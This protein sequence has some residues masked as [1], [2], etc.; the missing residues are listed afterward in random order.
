MHTHH[1]AFLS[2]ESFLYDLIYTV[3]GF[4]MV[5]HHTCSGMKLKP[6]ITLCVLVYKYDVMS[7]VQILC[8]N[9]F[10]KL[11]FI[12]WKAFRP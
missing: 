5:E 11:Q 1:Y 8:D 6:T 3:H 12:F 7:V 4:Q 10:N 9:L 2:E